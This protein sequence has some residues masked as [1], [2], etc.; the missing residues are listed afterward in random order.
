M[1]ARDR[2]QVSLRSDV[3]RLL[4]QARHPEPGPER[5]RQGGEHRATFDRVEKEF[6]VPGRGHHR[7]LGVR[8][9]L[10]RRHGQAAD[11]ASLTT[12]AYDCRRGDMFRDELRAALQIIDRGDMTRRDDRLVG[13][14]NRP[15]AV[16]A[17]ALLEPCHR[18]R[19][20][21]PPQ[22][23]PTR[24]NHRLDGGLHR[25]R[26]APRR[27]MARGGAG[28]AKLPWEQADLAI[29]HPRRSGR[30]G[31]SQAPTGE[32][33]RRREPASLVLPMG[34]NGP[35]FLAYPNF[36]VYHGVEP[37]AEL[38]DDGRYLAPAPSSAR[39]QIRRRRR[40]I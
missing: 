27:A 24:P 2:K 5:A 31:A 37:V 39:R 11:H 33:S 35:A 40:V 3:P 34:R 22:P 4:R 19:W 38:R 6:G 8:E 18:L 23:D 14:R 36:D 9:R 15:D 13:R 17:V 16:P 7:V 28:A 10:R 25:P 12:L 1:I 32:P 20:R 30:T 29:K 21:R 26:L